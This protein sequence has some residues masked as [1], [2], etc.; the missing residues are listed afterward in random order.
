MGDKDAES[1]QE[2]QHVTVAVQGVA[3]AASIGT[4]VGRAYARPPADHEIYNLIGRVSSEWAHLEHTLDRI[5][6]LLAG[7]EPPVGACITAQMMGIWPRTL[8]ITALLALGGNDTFSKRIKT[9]ETDCRMP[10]IRRNRFVHDPW[11][12][13]QHDPMLIAQHKSMAKGEYVFGITE[14]ARSE[15]DSLLSAIVSLQK[16][17]ENL[18]NDIKATLSASQQTQP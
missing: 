13:A 2:P 18:R 7:L 6:W 9:F 14:V 15:F 8:S 12:A 10:S 1:K 11:Y 16:T 3:A 17:A 5:I 4:A